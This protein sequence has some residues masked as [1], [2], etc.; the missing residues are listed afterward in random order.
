MIGE[1]K[2]A[3]APSLVTGSAYA[4]GATRVS[5]QIPE[6]CESSSSVSFEGQALRS[7]V[8]CSPLYSSRVYIRIMPAPVR[9]S[10]ATLT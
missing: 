2:T 10:N 6:G 1:A 9:S 7:N 5:D 8:E 4:F 3:A